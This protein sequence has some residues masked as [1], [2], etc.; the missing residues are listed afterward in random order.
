M[1]LYLPTHK[2]PNESDLVAQALHLPETEVRGLLHADATV[3]RPMAERISAASGV[4]ID[5]LAPFI[6]LPLR[7]FYSRAVCGTTVF[8]SAN[9]GDRG[10]MAVPMAFQSALAG[11]L[12]AV[13][14]VED[15]A[16]LRRASLPAVS[17]INLLRPLGRLLNEPAAKH[18]S[19]R[20]VCQD[21]I[22]LDTYARKFGLPKTV[23][24]PTSRG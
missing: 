16:N 22:Y 8:G 9:G 19:G 24:V 21:A 6:G 17:K 20:C 7:A 4:S 18:P 11:I 14:L 23:C 3:N 5:A 15:A 1:C 12:L 10:N 2:V 13:E